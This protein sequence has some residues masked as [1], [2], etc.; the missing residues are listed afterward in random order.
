MEASMIRERDR[1]GAVGLPVLLGLL[2]AEAAS[3]Y[4]IIQGAQAG[5]PLRVGASAVLL[6]LLVFLTFGFFMVNPN[7]A[8]VLQLFG[9]YV[10]TAKQPGL[11]WANPFYTKKRISLRVRNF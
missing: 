9:S 10:G 2:V 6:T 7:E 5:E 4:F 3:I 1:H 8:R 11:R